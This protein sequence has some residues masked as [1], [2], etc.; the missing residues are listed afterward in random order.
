VVDAGLTVGCGH[1][2]A[3]HGEAHLPAR[4]PRPAAATIHASPR[5]APA[6]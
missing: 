4:V 6:H 3:H 1:E 2:L 5:G